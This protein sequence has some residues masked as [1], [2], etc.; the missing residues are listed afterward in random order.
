MDNTNGKIE[1]HGYYNARRV[2]YDTSP[3]IRKYKPFYD[4]ILSVDDQ[5]IN[6]SNGVIKLVNDLTAII[7]NINAANNK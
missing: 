3:I 5:V 4:Y 1:V 6:D 7:T 2:R